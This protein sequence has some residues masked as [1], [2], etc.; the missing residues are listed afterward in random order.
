VFDDAFALHVIEHFADLLGRELV[1]IEKRDEA[2]NGPLEVDVVLPER[3]VGV[4]EKSLG[5]Q[6]ST[7]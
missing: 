1:V 4:D 5:G 6:A 2:A 3:V 7:S